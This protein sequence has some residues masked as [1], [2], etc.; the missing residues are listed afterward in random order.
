[1]FLASSEGLVVFWSNTDSQP[2]FSD[3]ELGPHI[4]LPVARLN[5]D[6]SY[7]VIQSSLDRTEPGKTFA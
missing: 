3:F 4:I 1:M 7:I 5:Q 2:T 6:R